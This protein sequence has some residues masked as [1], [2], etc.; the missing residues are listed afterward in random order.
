M[1]ARFKSI[2]VNQWRYIHRSKWVQ[3]FYASLHSC[4]CTQSPDTVNTNLAV[5]F[6]PSSDA[7]LNGAAVAQ[8][9]WTQCVVCIL[10]TSKKFR[11]IYF[12]LSSGSPPYT[13]NGAKFERR[14]SLVQRSPW[15]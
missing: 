9:L 3:S 6:I 14:A 15:K 13:H 8:L 2:R 10:C 12:F 4:H 11:M 5:S 1:A 7:L